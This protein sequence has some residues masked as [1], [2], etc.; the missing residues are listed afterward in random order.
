MWSQAV[1]VHL[2]LS[3]NQL[4]RPSWKAWRIS[5]LRC[6]KK[7]KVGFSINSLSPGRCGSNFTHL[8]FHLI[9]QNSSCKIALRWMPPNLTNQKSTLI[10]ITRLKCVKILTSQRLCTCF[11][12]Y[13]VLCVWHKSTRFYQYPLELVLWPWNNDTHILQGYFTGAGAII[14][15]PQCQRINPEGFV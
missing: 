8:I 2:L 1:P 12:I 5:W 11:D 7:P 9:I 10:G 13:G 6:N 15:L 14:W 3:L 4:W